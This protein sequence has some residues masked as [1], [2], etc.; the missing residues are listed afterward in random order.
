[1]QKNLARSTA[2]HYL[3]ERHVTTGVALLIGMSAAHRGT[4]DP[5]V[6][7]VLR[8]TIISFISFLEARLSGSE[9]HFAWPTEHE[10]F[11]TDTVTDIRN[12][13]W[14]CPFFCLS[15]VYVIVDI[16]IT[17]VCSSLLYS[18]LLSVR[19]G[20]SPSCKND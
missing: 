5:T 8:Y 6:A 15:L 9:R 7:K 10:L 4:M 1:M 3:A 14:C 11:C 18:R 19:A 20:G 2:Y 17:V 16:W 12:P 13:V